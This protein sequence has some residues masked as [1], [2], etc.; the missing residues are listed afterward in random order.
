[1]ARNAS[2]FESAPVVKGGLVALGL[3]VELSMQR[4]TQKQRPHEWGLT[5]TTL[6]CNLRY[7]A[8]SKGDFSLMQWGAEQE[9]GKAPARGAWRV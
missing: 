8:A 1:M 3:V 7:V 4:S 9:L 2:I 6:D 5:D